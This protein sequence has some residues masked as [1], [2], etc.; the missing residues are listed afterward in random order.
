MQSSWCD[1]VARWSV[2]CFDA[3]LARSSFNFCKDSGYFSKINWLLDFKFC[4]FHCSPLQWACWPFS[5][6]SWYCF[7]SP[8]GTFVIEKCYIM[9]ILQINIFLQ[10]FAN[11]WF[12]KINYVKCLMWFCAS[13][14]VAVGHSVTV[15]LHHDKCCLWYMHSASTLLQRPPQVLYNPI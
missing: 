8:C 12:K 7:A 4:V 14:K 9:N 10:M 5:I 6:H 1:L 11:L 2:V 15:C 13:E 3:C